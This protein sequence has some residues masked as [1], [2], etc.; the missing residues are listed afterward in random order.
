[1]YDEFAVLRSGVEYEDFCGVSIIN[2]EVVNGNFGGNLSDEDISEDDSSDED[3][4]DR[5]LQALSDDEALSSESSMEDIC[6]A[7]AN[8]GNVGD[9]STSGNPKGEAADIVRR[10]AADEAFFFTEFVK[11]WR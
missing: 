4:S 6:C 11:R 9:C 8:G 5:R 7:A 3:S 10:F 1:M 2:G